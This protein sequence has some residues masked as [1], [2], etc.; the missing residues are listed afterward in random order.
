MNF[1]GLWTPEP[2]ILGNLC[3]NP[4]RPTPTTIY[5][6]T[7]IP[8]TI[9]TD[10]T[11]NTPTIK[12]RNATST[13]SIPT[14]GNTPHITPIPKPSPISSLHPALYQSLHQQVNS[15][16]RQAIELDIHQVIFI[17]FIQPTPIK[18]TLLHPHYTHTSLILH[19]H[20]TNYYTHT[21][22]TLHTKLLCTL[23]HPSPHLGKHH[24]LHLALH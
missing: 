23:L 20:Y 3:I 12:P 24:A 4:T 10:I 14:P 19:S 2:G 9:P 5:Y 18:T 7:S 13:T 22:S 6:M 16:I 1:W 8:I 15:P 21:T 17:W 11:S